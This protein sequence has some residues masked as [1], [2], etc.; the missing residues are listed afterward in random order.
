MNTLNKNTGVFLIKKHKQAHRRINYTVPRE[1]WGSSNPITNFLKR[2]TNDDI[3]CIYASSLHLP[4]PATYLPFRGQW[5]T[6]CRPASWPWRWRHWPGSPLGCRRGWAG[7]GTWPH[8]NVKTFLFMVQLGHETFYLL[9]YLYLVL[10]W[11]TQVES[12]RRGRSPVVVYALAVYHFW[13]ILGGLHR[14]RMLS[15]SSGQT[16]RFISFGTRLSLSISR[17]ADCGFRLRGLTALLALGQ[18]Y[19]I[20]AFCYSQNKFSLHQQSPYVGTENDQLGPML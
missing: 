17:R 18:E 4:E 14:F 8:H 11:F 5:G 16:S 6:S 3:D 20:F 10:R 12:L 9:V 1:V 2:T 13:F 15:W 19:P 7:P